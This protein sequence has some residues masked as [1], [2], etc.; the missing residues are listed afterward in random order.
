ML[1]EACVLLTATLGFGAMLDV[2]SWAYGKFRA[3]WFDRRGI[4]T[5]PS[6]GRRKEDLLYAPQ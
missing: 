1:L 4:N 3:A 5:N 2:S 6:I